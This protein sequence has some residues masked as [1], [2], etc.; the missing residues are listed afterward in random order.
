MAYCAEHCGRTIPARWMAA[1]FST[2]EVRLALAEQFMGDHVPNR[3][4][5]SKNARFLEIN[6]M[7][8]AG[9]GVVSSVPSWLQSP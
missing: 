1:L 6:L 5:C 4:W 8:Y 9:D 7:K 3:R 2:P